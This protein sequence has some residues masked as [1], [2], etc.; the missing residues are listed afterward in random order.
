MSESNYV[1]ATRRLFSS[2]YIN[3]NSEKSE[4]SSIFVHHYMRHGVLTKNNENI[5]IN[6]CSCLKNFKANVYFQKFAGFNKKK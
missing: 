2:Q 4:K 5:F 3:I 1:H 6:I